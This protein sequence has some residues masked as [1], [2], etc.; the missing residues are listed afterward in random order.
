MTFDDIWINLQTDL[1]WQYYAVAL[2]MVWPLVRI[3]RRA[4]LS[5]FFAA[6]LIVPMVGL[7]VV[8]GILA[9]KPW[10]AVPPL[11]FKKRKGEEA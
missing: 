1:V 5:P 6:A 7:T 8:A 9:L 2:L 11:V 10:P 3:F 4:G